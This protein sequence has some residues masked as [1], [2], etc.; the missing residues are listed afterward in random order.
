MAKPEYIMLRL[1]IRH[2]ALILSLGWI[3][4]AG[5][6]ALGA[7][8]S[9]ALS[10]ARSATQARMNATASAKQKE[11]EARALKACEGSFVAERTACLVREMSRPP[12]STGAFGVRPNGLALPNSAPS[13]RNV[14][15]AFDSPGSTTANSRPSPGAGEPS[16]SIVPAVAT[17]R[18]G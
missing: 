12:G 15:I 17:Q 2:V 5:A 4:V 1:R 9:S 7:H 8:E 14:D 13:D 16:D 3:G 10:G 11:R 6:Q 18:K